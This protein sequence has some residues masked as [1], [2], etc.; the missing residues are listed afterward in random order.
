MKSELSSA[1]QTPCLAFPPRESCNLQNPTRGPST[2]SSKLTATLNER[3][4]A[5]SS[6]TYSVLIDYIYNRDQLASMRPKGDVGHPANLHE[7]PE[8]LKQIRKR[9]LVFSFFFFP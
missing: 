7:A 4:W 8:H 1:L 3:L 9:G 5:A 2:V 6:Y